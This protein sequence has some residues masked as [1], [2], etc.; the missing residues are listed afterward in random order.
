M[1]RKLIVNVV[2]DL[3]DSEPLPGAQPVRF[4]IDGH[5]YQVDA[6][7]GCAA[8]LRGVLDP[9]VSRASRAGVLPELLP[10]RT[11]RPDAAAGGRSP[12]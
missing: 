11:P 9:F 6:C 1:A 7:P 10:G 5:V 12:R 3:H 8:R 4:G 2:C